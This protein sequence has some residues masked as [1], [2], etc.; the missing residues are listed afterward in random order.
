MARNWRRFRPTCMSTA[1][2]AVIEHGRERKRMSI[3]RLADVLGLHNKFQLYRWIQ[4]GSIPARKIHALEHACG[5]YFITQYL[6]T[7]AHKLLVDIPTGRTAQPSDVAA[8][9]GACADA[10]SAL[11]AFAAGRADADSTH[12]ALT[13]AMER[14]AIERAQVEHSAFPELDLFPTSEDTDA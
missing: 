9:Q 3:D 6:A 5:A 1:I 11:V 10:V 12:A 2:E 4:E 7:A 14:L 8:L 13:V